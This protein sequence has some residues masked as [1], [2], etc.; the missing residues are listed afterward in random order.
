MNPIIRWSMVIV[1]GTMTLFF[2]Y[3]ASMILAS[4][5]SLALRPT[6][7]SIESV[8]SHSLPT[9]YVE[10]SDGVLAPIITYAGTPPKPT[11]VRGGYLTSPSALRKWEDS[12]S[13]EQQI[14]GPPNSLLVSMN[15]KEVRRL[16]PVLK[17]T[18]ASTYP[19]EELRPIPLN[20]T[21]ESIS[22]LS[23]GFPPELKETTIRYL[24]FEEH[25]LREFSFF[26]F[27]G[28]I[29]A[30][31]ACFYTFRVKPPQGPATP[32]PGWTPES[33]QDHILV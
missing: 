23:E 15:E 31:C 30:A 16:W 7:V 13:T 24:D 9:G 12:G 11:N 5:S 17:D 2:W 18:T 29:T 1:H 22:F 26:V 20:V 33:A 3:H 14:E 27:W 28:L 10:I 21:G 32:D 4:G 25:P 6:P 8:E 19:P